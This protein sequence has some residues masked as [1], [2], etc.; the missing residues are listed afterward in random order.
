M[1]SRIK[2]KGKYEGIIQQL[3]EYE[4]DKRIW[5]DSDEYRWRED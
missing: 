4:R 5:R 3:R 2:Y 1:A